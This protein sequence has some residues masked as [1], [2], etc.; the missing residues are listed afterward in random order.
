[1]LVIVVHIKADGTS[2]VDGADSLLRRD[3]GIGCAAACGKVHR[4]AELCGLLFHQRDQRLPRSIFN[5]EIRLVR[6]SAVVL[7]LK[8]LLFHNANRP[9]PFG[10]PVR[11]VGEKL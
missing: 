2:G 1:M 11:K 9:A 7:C 3:A 5:Y 4:Y 8:R 10:G 6:H